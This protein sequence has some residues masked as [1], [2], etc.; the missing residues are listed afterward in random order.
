M[1]QMLK[2]HLILIMVLILC[3]VPSISVSASTKSEVYDSYFYDEQGKASIAPIGFIPTNSLNKLRDGNSIADITDM[4][5]DPKGTLYLLQSKQSKIILLD[6]NLSFLKEIS[7]NDNGNKVE[8]VGAKGLYV[9]ETANGIQIYIADSE[10]RRILKTDESG[11]L[12][13]VF[14][15]PDADIFSKEEEFIPEK[16]IVNDSNTVLALCKGIYKGAVVFSDDG[17]FLGFYG[18]NRVKVNAQ[19]LYDFAWK[20]LFGAERT[21]SMKT[22]VPIEFT[23]FDIDEKGFIYTITSSDKSDKNISYINYKG[24]NLLDSNFTFGDVENLDNNNKELPT[25]FVDIVNMGGGIFAA[26]D[27]TRGRV[28]IYEKNG[29]NLMVFGNIGSSA[30]MFSQVGAIECIEDNIYIYDT[31]NK[32]ITVFSPNS[33]GKNVLN[34]TRQFLEGKYDESIEIWESVLENNQ[35]F[36]LAY[37]S[38]GR[39]LTGKND[40]ISAMKY[41]EK[42]NSKSD[43]S[44]AFAEQRKI[45]LTEWLWLILVGIIV[46]TIVMIVISVLYKKKTSQKEKT[47]TIFTLLSHPKQEMIHIIREKPKTGLISIIIVAVWFL[48]EV[49]SVNA[50]GFIFSTAKENPLNLGIVFASTFGLVLLFVV[51]NFLITAIFN[52]N[53]TFFDIFKVVA[54]ALIPYIIARFIR[55]IMS[56]F[57]TLDEQSFM[58]IVIAIGLLWSF[59]ILLIGLSQIHEFTALGTVACF[60]FT[61]LGMALVI[62]LLLLVSSVVAQMIQFV[63]DIWSEFLCIIS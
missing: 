44:E 58:S 28:F 17:E 48:L 53:G 59:V 26:L 33:Y 35:S 60:L 50:T 40:Y 9:V 47:T 24:I 2:K 16:V 56:N 32:D 42:A 61:V 5:A 15:K 39:A 27:L 6:K 8:F 46:I 11:N 21:K 1:K 49:V 25:A 43:Y 19:L 29:H 20:S 38:I 14:T 34:A 30:G 36:S 23:N 4:F 57:C 31:A 62:F 41:F 22:Y 51:V 52:G 54:V 45:F 18:S 10:N 7:I 37:L 55:L 3:L 63:K 12:L 13:N